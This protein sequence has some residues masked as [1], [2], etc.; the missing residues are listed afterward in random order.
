MRVYDLGGS[1]RKSVIDERMSR[2][3]T[4][5]A[6]LRHQTR[7]RRGACLE[8]REIRPRARLSVVLAPADVRARVL[9]LLFVARVLEP[10]P[11]EH[12]RAEAHGRVHRTDTRELLVD[13][14]GLLRAE[15]ATAYSLARR[16][17]A[18]K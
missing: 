17:W 12:H 8:A 5:T 4:R 1:Q 2:H 13:D 6:A 9:E 14:R 7:A 16:T 18:A 10:H 15:A 3:G 11:D